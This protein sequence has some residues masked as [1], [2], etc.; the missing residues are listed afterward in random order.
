MIDKGLKTAISALARFETVFTIDKGIKTAI[1]ALARFGTVYTIDKGLKTAISA[2]ARFGTVYTIDKD[3]ETAIST[4]A[5]LGLCTRSTKAF[6]WL[7][8]TCD[9][10]AEKRTPR[11]YDVF[12]NTTAQC[13]KACTVTSLQLIAKETR[14]GQTNRD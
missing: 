12:W 11:T 2:L 3:L 14:L 13:R 5:R 10:F 4:L 7:F 8:C 6:P 1:S 9:T